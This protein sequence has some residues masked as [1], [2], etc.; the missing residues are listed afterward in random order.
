MSKSFLHSALSILDFRPIGYLHNTSPLL[1]S[2]ILFLNDIHNHLQASS[3]IAL[4]FPLLSF[5]LLSSILLF[6]FLTS[7]SNRLYDRLYFTY[8]WPNIHFYLHL[9]LFLSL[10]LSSFPILLC[11]TFYI[12]GLGFHFTYSHRSPPSRSSSFLLGSP[13]SFCQ[14]D[15]SH[16]YSWGC[17]GH[18]ASGAREDATE[19]FWNG[20]S[21]PVVQNIKN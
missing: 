14:S 16:P 4:T 5:I 19:V 17:I 8:L 20:K 2:V 7:P 6:A 11:L 18:R 15:H 10:F 9:C 1:P 13:A 21:C 12:W 3:S